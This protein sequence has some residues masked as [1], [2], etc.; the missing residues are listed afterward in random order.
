MDLQLKEELNE[1]KAV[2]ISVHLQPV[3]PTGAVM[4]SLDIA[5][6]KVQMLI[7]QLP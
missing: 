7:S 6:T 3:I 2:T 5:T 4:S 1:L